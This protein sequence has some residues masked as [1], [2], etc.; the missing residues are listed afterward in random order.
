MIFCNPKDSDSVRPSGGSGRC[1]ENLQGGGGPLDPRIPCRD[2]GKET[3]FLSLKQ[4]GPSHCVKGRRLYFRL[5]CGENLH[6][7]ACPLTPFPLLCTINFHLCI[8]KIQHT[9]DEW[10][11]KIQFTFLSFSLIS[12]YFSP[13]IIYNAI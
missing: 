6:R 2:A 3:V 1:P 9:V 13:D 8:S 11:L 10:N 5:R 7:Q 4:G 12:V